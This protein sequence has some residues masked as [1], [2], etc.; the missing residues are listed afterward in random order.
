[1]QSPVG[2]GHN[3]PAASGVSLRNMKSIPEEPA[4]ADPSG[5]A[6]F[7]AGRSF[8]PLLNSTLPLA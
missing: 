1:M 8:L 6:D 7:C 3:P 2:P 4:Q 5:A